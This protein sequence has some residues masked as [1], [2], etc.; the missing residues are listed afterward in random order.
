M[1]K[2]EKLEFGYGDRRVLK[3]LGLEIQ[4]G[5]LLSLIGV[6]GSGKSTLLK[7][8]SRSLKP[9]QGAVLLDGESIFRKNTREVARKM[10][11]LPQSPKI[12]EDFTVR[13]LAGYGRFPHLGW[14]GHLDNTDHAIIEWAMRS[15]GILS[16]EHRLVSTLSGGERQRAWLSLAI[17]QKTDLLLLDEP[18]TFLDI[19]CQVEILELVRRLNQELGITVIMVLH[20][21]NQAARYSKT[22]AALKDGKLLK[23]GKPEEIITEEIL[24]QVF[25]VRGRVYRDP[26]HGCPYFIP[27]CRTEETAS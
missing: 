5:E 6:N 13:D 15:T 23:A 11:I 3:D 8:L 10:A 21:V 20:D 12:P 25:N 24:F 18:T 4:K 14:T 17:A 9:H 27:C 7:T 2:A 1:L 16:L 26:E 19:A 22:I